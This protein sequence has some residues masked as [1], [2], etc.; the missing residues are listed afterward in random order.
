[1]PPLKNEV[2]VTPLRAASAELVHRGRTFLKYSLITAAVI[3]LGIGGWVGSMSTLHTG[4]FAMPVS[5][6]VLYV[7]GR[8][9]VR[10][11]SKSWIKELS[12]KHDVAAEK[13]EP[14][15]AKFL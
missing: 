4:A 2:E 12:K 3:G 8:I 5:V 6:A 7:I 10:I 1:M 14:A 15:L 11:R 13:L 9:V